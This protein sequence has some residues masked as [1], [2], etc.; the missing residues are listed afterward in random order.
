MSRVTDCDYC[1]HIR[2]CNNDPFGG[3]CCSTCWSNVVEE[4]DQRQ[5]NELASRGIY[6]TLVT[7][8]PASEV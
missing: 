3:T 7:E 4:D 2:L 6:V 1:G 8:A 5:V